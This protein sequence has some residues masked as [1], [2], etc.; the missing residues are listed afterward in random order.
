MSKGGKETR[1][2]EINRKK[3]AS[4]IY[5]ARCFQRNKMMSERV[6]SRLTEIYQA[7]RKPGSRLHPCLNPTSSGMSY[8]YSL[9]SLSPFKRDSEWQESNEEGLLSVTE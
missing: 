8:S 4:E 7:S 2:T 9:T 1:K 6:Q 3:T 5:E